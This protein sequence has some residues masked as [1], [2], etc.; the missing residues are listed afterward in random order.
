M[1]ANMRRPFLS[2]VVKLRFNK[3]H[4]YTQFVWIC[5]FFTSLARFSACRGQSDSAMNE[6]SSSSG[7]NWTQW[8]RTS[9]ICHINLTMIVPSFD[10]HY[11]NLHRTPY[12]QAMNGKLPLLNGKS[13]ITA[14]SASIFFIFIPQRMHLSVVTFEIVSTH[15]EYEKCA[16]FGAKSVMSTKHKAK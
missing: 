6:P 7:I 2:V 9:Y 16:F 1:A 10:F 8:Y 4:K 5:W 11:E 3:L 14:L 12:W 13:I 15:I